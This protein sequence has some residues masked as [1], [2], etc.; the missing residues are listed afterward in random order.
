MSH[1]VPSA[2]GIA[3]VV[4]SV[5]V[6]VSVALDTQCDGPFDRPAIAA[7]PQKKEDS[8]RML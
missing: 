8:G 7:Q 5:Y 1:S 4:G 2:M 6:P 3:G